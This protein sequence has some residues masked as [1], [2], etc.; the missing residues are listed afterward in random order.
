M[1]TA[2]TFD[3]TRCK[4]GDAADTTTATTATVP[5]GWFGPGP[6]AQYCNTCSCS[7]G[8]MFCTSDHCD[9]KCIG[10]ECKGGGKAEKCSP[11]LIVKE[12]AHW[13]G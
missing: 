11:G 6:G 13:Y 5:S 10:V 7:M 9:P 1:P 4:Y 8:A 2:P 12:R 3:P